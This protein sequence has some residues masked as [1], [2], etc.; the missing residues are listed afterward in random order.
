M[1]VLEGVSSITTLTELHFNSSAGKVAYF[2]ALFPYV[3]LI[4]LLIRGVTLP[5]AVEGIT[6]FISPKW[7]KILEPQVGNKA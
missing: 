5:G 1:T 4:I 6:Y 2:T 7:E 3:V